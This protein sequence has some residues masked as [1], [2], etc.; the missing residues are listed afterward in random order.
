MRCDW[1]AVA[2]A[3]AVWSEFTAFYPP[4]ALDVLTRLH[5]DTPDVEA[6]LSQMVAHPS[7]ATADALACTWVRQHADTVASWVTLVTVRLATA[8]ATA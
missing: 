2:A 8:V 3:K 6:A 1:P 5:V 4:A 7:N